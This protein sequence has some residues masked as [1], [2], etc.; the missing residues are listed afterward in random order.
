VPRNRP[1]IFLSLSEIIDILREEVVPFL[2][3][4]STI[5]ARTQALN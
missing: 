3:G 1:M 5:V 4:T 2:G